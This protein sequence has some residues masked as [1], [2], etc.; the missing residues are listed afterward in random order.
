MKFSTVMEFRQRCFF[1]YD[2]PDKEKE[3][4]FLYS[5]SQPC[6]QHLR[7]ENDGGKFGA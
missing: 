1:D 2:F 4:L 7:A 3:S 5:L 6:L